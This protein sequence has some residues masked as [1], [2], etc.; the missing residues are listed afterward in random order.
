M[1]GLLR[2]R[3]VIDLTQFWPGGSADA[4]TSK[5]KVN[6]GKGSFAFAADGKKFKATN[7]LDKAIVIGASK[8]PVIDAQSRVTVRL[9]GIDAPELHYK[10]APLRKSRLRSPRPDARP[11]TPR[12]KPS[13]ASTGVRRRRWRWRRSSPL[14]ARGR[15]AARSIRWSITRTS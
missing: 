14:S 8:K 6:V 7:V 12:T 5:V 11:T 10:A 9:Q 4:D 3:G 15:S 13:A 2:I 1:S